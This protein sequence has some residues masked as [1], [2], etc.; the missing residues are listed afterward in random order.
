MPDTIHALHG[1]DREFDRSLQSKVI[2]IASTQEVLTPYH[3]IEPSPGPSF[4]VVIAPVLA[5]AIGW[6]LLKRTLLL[7]KNSKGGY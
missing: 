3:M 4:G 5:V 1:V 7:G 6:A 2:P